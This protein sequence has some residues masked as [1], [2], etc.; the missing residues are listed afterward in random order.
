MTPRLDYIRASPTPFQ[1]MLAMEKHLHAAVELPLLHLVKL[2]ASMLN[3]CAYCVD[4]HWKEA[5][6]DGEDELKLAA[7]ACWEES[8]LFA[9]RERAALAW[10]DALTNIQEGHAPD[11]VFARVKEHFDDTGLADLTWAIGIINAWN[12]VA[13]AMRPTPGLYKPVKR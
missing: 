3:G 6:A 1:T 12:R 5:R 8:P 7:L 4:M 11:S 10:T 2:R 9:E 13:I